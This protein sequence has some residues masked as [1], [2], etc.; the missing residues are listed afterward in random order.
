MYYVNQS[1]T[2][3][4]F[5]DELKQYDFYL[6]GL[7]F[8][9][10]GILQVLHVYWFGLFVKMVLNFLIKGEAEDIQEKQKSK[11][12]TVGKK[13]KAKLTAAAKTKPKNE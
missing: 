10:L 11:N 5:E 9:Y 7:Y 4:F 13:E 6:Y 3:G 2:T 1:P 8:V 12:P